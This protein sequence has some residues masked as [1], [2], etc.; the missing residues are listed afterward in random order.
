MSQISREDRMVLRKAIRDYK[1]LKGQISPLEKAKRAKHD[2]IKEIVAK[3]EQDFDTPE[4]KTDSVPT[5]REYY[6]RDKLDEMIEAGV[7]DEDTK[8][9][10]LQCRIATDSYSLYV[11]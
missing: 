7:F 2:V 8:Q 10:I 9:L 5:H 4:G 1:N 6:D 11:R 3:Y